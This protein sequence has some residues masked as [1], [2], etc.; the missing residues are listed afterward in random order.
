M[1]LSQYEK[2][3]QQAVGRLGVLKEQRTA[4]E[5]RQTTLDRDEKG[6]EKA[7]TLIQRIA[8]QTQEQLRYHIED[9][10]QLA[11][12]TCFP[13][14]YEFQVQFEIKR[15]KTEAELRLIEDGHAMN[16]MDANG[17]GVVD[18]AAFA[19]RIAGWTLGRTANVIIL[20]EPFRFLSRELRPKAAEI[21]QALSRRL[22]LQFIVVTHADEQIDRS[23]RVF[24]ISRPGDRSVVRI[25]DV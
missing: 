25:E 20:D 10:V 13:D 2:F 19:L 24:H 21:I 11:I 7:Q 5:V 8:Q 3:T 22:D 4:A 9:I 1:T 16:P 23:D 14:R 17:G 15:G 18:I 12:D 6:L